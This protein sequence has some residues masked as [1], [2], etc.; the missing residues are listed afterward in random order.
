M[1][2]GRKDSGLWPVV[3]RAALMPIMVD[4]NVCLFTSVD[5]SQNCNPPGKFN[6]PIMQHWTPVSTSLIPVEATRMLV[7]LGRDLV[8][9]IMKISIQYQNKSYQNDQVGKKF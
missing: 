2:T 6:L 8:R 9:Q 3:R 5:L 1:A 7:M 4:A